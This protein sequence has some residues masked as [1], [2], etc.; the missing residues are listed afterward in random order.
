MQEENAR[1]QCRR[2]MQGNYT[3]HK[4]TRRIMRLS[5]YAGVLYFIIHMASYAYICRNIAYSQDT[6]KYNYVVDRI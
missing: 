3:F 2:I 5:G 6:R 4:I 1:G